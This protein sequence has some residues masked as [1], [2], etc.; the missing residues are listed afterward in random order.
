M[1]KNWLGPLITW[2]P[3]RLSFSIR[4]R[5]IFGRLGWLLI[6]F[7]TM[8]SRLLGR[9]ILRYSRVLRKWRLR[10][11]RKFL[12]GWNKWLRRV[13]RKMPHKGPQHSCWKTTLTSRRSS[14]TQYSTQAAPSK[15]SKSKWTQCHCWATSA[16]S[17]KATKTSSYSQLWYRKR[18]SLGTSSHEYWHFT[19]KEVSCTLRTS[20]WILR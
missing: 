5:A 10:L 4:K 12:W 18:C 11:R 17:R 9:I 7:I 3:R 19:G 20:M 16:L 8:S 1:I 13:W 2:V 15:S 6:S 14:S